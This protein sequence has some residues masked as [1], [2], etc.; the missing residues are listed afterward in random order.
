MFGAITGSIRDIL[1]SGQQFCAA[2]EPFLQIR[3]DVMSHGVSLRYLIVSNGRLVPS[4]ERLSLTARMFLGDSC[5]EAAPIQKP[6]VFSTGV[7]TPIFSQKCQP[8]SVQL[9]G[10]GD[11]QHRN[12]DV[13]VRAPRRRLS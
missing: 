2:L 7:L 1:S 9:C 13:M 3:W 6:D 8:S 4:F 5:A 11:R 12:S 10:R